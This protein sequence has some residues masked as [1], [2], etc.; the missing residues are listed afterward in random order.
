ML[1]V[2]KA[3]RK[4]NSDYIYGVDLVRF[5]CAVGVGIY[6]LTW[7]TP[8][9]AW[10]MPFGWIGVQIFF[11]ISGLVIAN[12]AHGASGRQFVIN[13][14]LRLYPTAW[15]AAIVSYPLF[16]WAVGKN[17]SNFR[18][19][20]LSL[21]LLHGP[22]LAG[23]Y[24]TLPIELSFYFLVF[25]L[26]KSNGFDNIQWLAIILILWS[27]PYLLT[28][29]LNTRGLVHWSWI[30]FS[31]GAWN[32]SLL[33]YDHYFGLGILVWLF[34]DNWGM[35]LLRH[36]P[37]FGLGILVWLFKEKRIDKLGFLA[38]ALAFVLGFM[39]IYARAVQLSPEFARSAH[40]LGKPW[41]HLAIWSNIAFLLGF[42]A[43]LLSVKF[44]HLFPA[45]AV[46]RRTVR[47]LGLM[48]YPFY[49]LH[50]R[51]G[52]YVV[53]QLNR[54]G[55]AHLPGVMLA[56]ICTGAISLIIASFFE[57]ALR[58]LLRQN[59]GVLNPTPKEQVSQAT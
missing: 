16:L 43:I 38:A 56:L 12:S 22:F 29:S 48:T 33:R 34:K 41:T 2:G 31:H 54:V 32:M 30:D 40:L 35:S 17:G 55:V 7:R 18:P 5:A 8:E 37:Y 59:V 52:G 23:A 24:W 9:I 4:P 14:F 49:L 13:R 20:F 15:C 1:E 50:E 6:H 51:V 42:A 57:P 47:Q 26:I 36:G 44:N 28:L 39:E 53:Y 3:A 19:L 27:T 25:L 46:M 58:G 11:V 21:V 45:N 10:A